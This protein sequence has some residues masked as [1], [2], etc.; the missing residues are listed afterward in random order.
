MTDHEILHRALR[1]GLLLAVDG[2][3]VRFSAP[4]GVLSDE[5]TAAIRRLEHEIICLYEERTVTLV[6]MAGMP[7]PEAEAHAAM[8]LATNPLGQARPR[9]R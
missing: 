3:R 2:D 9:E 8:E 5:L 6:R 4:E 7:W 1:V